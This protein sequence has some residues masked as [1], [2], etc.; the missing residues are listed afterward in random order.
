MELCS[1]KTPEKKIYSHFN[2]LKKREREEDLDNYFIDNFKNV[3]SKLSYAPHII[4]IANS[5]LIDFI[6]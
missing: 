4:E 6:F 1:K 2:W 3:F 5:K